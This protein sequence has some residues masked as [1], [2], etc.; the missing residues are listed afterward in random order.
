MKVSLL[1]LAISSE[2]TIADKHD[3]TWKVPRQTLMELLWFG[4]VP[5]VL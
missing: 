1:V 2:F 5:F 4:L 3:L